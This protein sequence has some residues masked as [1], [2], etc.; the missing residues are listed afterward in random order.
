MQFNVQMD[1][2]GF[3][4]SLSSTAKQVRNAEM[5]ALTRTGYDARKAVQAEMRQVFDR[6][7]RYS[8]NAFEV[9]GATKTKLEARVAQKIAVGGGKPRDWFNPQVF[10]GPRK[11]KAFERA[12]SA[13]LGLPIG[14]TFFLPGPGAKL[15]AYGNISGGQLGQILSDL[16]AR[17]TDR[18]QNATERSR[19]R[20]KRARHV[21]IGRPG[22]RRYFIGVRDGSKVTCVLTVT[23]E[24]PTYR[25]RFDFFGVAMRAA[26]RHFPMQF[27]RAF[28]AA[29]SSRR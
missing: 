20:N 11:A 29:T 13:R 8:L 23:N 12:L 6:P 14:S 22:G 18:A 25:P 17:Q 2:I 4:R 7:T 15:D 9:I 27:E 28:K 16:G 24:V 21:V 3:V 1:S 26:R 19:K 10:G 5:V